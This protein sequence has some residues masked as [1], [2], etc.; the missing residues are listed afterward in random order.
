M[1]AKGYLYI[2]QP[3]LYKVKKGKSEMYLRNDSMFEEFV[4]NQ[5]LEEIEITANKEKVDKGVAKNIFKKLTQ[6]DNLVATLARR[7]DANLIKWIAHNEQWTP[8]TLKSADQLKKLL[9]EYAENAKKIVGSGDFSFRILEDEEHGGSQAE[10]TTTRH[11]LRTIT[12]DH[13]RFPKLL[14]VAGAAKNHAILLEAGKGAVRSC[15]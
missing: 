5:A 10:C 15:N 7:A 4:L 2:A 11:N 3:P 12:K 8:E 6:F 9:T 1:I 13:F 14:P